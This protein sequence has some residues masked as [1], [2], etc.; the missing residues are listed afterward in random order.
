[1]VTVRHMQE[2][3]SQKGELSFQIV[4]N[5]CIYDVLKIQRA[6]KIECQQAKTNSPGLTYKMSSFYSIMAL[7]VLHSILN[8]VELEGSTTAL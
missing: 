8:E 7:S 4:N 2:D 6:S 1:M 3:A 5:S